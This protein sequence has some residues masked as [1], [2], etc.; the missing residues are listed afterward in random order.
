MLGMYEGVICQIDCRFAHPEELRGKLQPEA[1]LGWWLAKITWWCEG[2]LMKS[3]AVQSHLRYQECLRDNSVLL[4]L[5]S[6]FL[7]FR[8]TISVSNI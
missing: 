7:T 3:Q 5:T 4:Q 2:F 8:D 1:R 6:Y